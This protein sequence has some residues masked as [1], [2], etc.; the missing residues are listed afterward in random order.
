VRATELIESV[1][2]LSYE[3]RLKTLRVPALKHRRLRG[4]VIDVFKIITN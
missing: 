4:D 2:R 1:K 3:D